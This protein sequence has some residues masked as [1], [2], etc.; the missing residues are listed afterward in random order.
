M[1]IFKIKH[2]QKK[3]FYLKFSSLFQGI[4]KGNHSLELIKLTFI[5]ELQ[6]KEETTEPYIL[7]SWKKKVSQIYERFIEDP[8]KTYYQIAKK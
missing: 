6:F 7:I 8:M 3:A 5:Y 4:S 1:T 2:R